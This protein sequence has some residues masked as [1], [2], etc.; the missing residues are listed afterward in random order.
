MI[1]LSKKIAMFGFLSCAFLCLPS[2]GY[3]SFSGSTLPHLKTVAVPLFEDDTAEFG[4][5]EELTN[6][7]IDAFTQ[8]NTLKIAD[9][10]VADSIITG[11]IVG[12]RDGAGAYDRAESVQEIRINISVNVKFEDLKKRQVV[13]EDR[14]T[15]VGTY[16]PNGGDDEQ[17]TR[18]EA[19]SEA[20]EKIT[21][22]ILN[23]SVSGW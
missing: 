19:I 15:Q 9:Q 2:C 13:W 18:E 4:V 20:I 22:E 5:K 11:K 6:S 12:V 14:I 3:Y 8:D 10:R 1:Y 7:I 16:S 21:T 23:R 17:T